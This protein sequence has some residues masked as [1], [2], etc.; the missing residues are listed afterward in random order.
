MI[1]GQ[2]KSVFHQFTLTTKNWA[3]PK[4]E[5]ALLPKSDGIAVMMSAFTSRDTCLGLETDAAMFGR[6]NLS[7]RGQ[8]HADKECAAKDI[9]NA[10]EKK[11]LKESPCVKHFGLE[12]KNEGCWGHNHM[13]FQSEVCA[14]CLQVVHS[15]FDFV[16]WFGHSGKHS[17]KR[18]C[19]LDAANMNSG[20]GGAQPS[21]QN[22]NLSQTDGCFLGPFDPI[23]A[24]DHMQ[25][26]TFLPDTLFRRCLLK[27]SCFVDVIAPFLMDRWFLRCFIARGFLLPGTKCT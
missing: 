1:F 13:T 19:G 5:W 27:G 12:A 3:G 23:L 14:D 4:G 6:I 20:F 25:S 8:K 21:T 18:N 10:V 2:H 24:L 16:F 9:F 22:V 26:M 11:C 15:D 17:K 7:M